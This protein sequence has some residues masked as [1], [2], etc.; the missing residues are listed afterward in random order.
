MSDDTVLL[1]LSTLTSAL[2]L[3]VF[4]NFGN[5]SM[6]PSATIFWWSYIKGVD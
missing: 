6:F 1:L 4:V 3:V 5:P 2:A